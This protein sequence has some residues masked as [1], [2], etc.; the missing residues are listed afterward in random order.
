MHLH[1]RHAAGHVEQGV[2]LRRRV[3]QAAADRQ[4]QVRLFHLAD[5]AGIGPDAEIAGEIVHRPVIQS[6]AAETDCHR[7]V[8]A[9]QEILDRRAACVGPAGTS[10]HSHRA[11][12]PRQH[13]A[14]LQQRRRIGMRRGDRHTR[15]IRHLCQR[16]LHLLRQGDHHRAGTAG[17]RNID[18]MGDNF[19]NALR[20][21]DLRDPFRDRGKH[22][23]VVDFL[24]CV[25]A[26]I[27]MRDLADE[28]Q[29]RRRVLHGDVDADR[30]VA[31][32]GTSGD[33]GSR[34][35]A[36]ELA[37]G[38]GHVD[39][40]RF[41]SAGDQLQLLPHVVE[42]IQRVEE[43]LAWHFEYVIDTLR[44]Q[45]VRQDA[46][47]HPRGNPSLTRLCQLHPCLLRWRL[48]AQ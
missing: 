30:A 35:A 43:A 22:P 39:R 1:D 27:L 37:V 7:N 34:R 42:A 20:L 6:L 18:R 3:T 13:R 33:E 36:G 16:A 15:Y 46:S 8:V 5:E 48:P 4:D 23:P 47:P 28:Q 38:L 17:C 21:V 9:M 26:G 44:H 24:E 32:A 11:T 2:T 14:Q 10:E 45:R 41:E 25:A 40:A 29:H 12:R 19:R 31:C